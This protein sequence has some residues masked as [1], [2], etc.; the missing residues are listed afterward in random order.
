MTTKTAGLPVHEQLYRGKA[1]APELVEVPPAS[2]LMIDG[3]GDPNTSPAYARAIR[4]LYAA[5]YTVKF[6]VKKAGGPD[7]RVPPLEGLWWGA[8]AAGFEAAGKDSWSWTMMIRLP[9]GAAAGL[10]T[11]ALAEA[12]RRKPD[13]PIGSLRVERF[14]EGRAAQV[15]YV[16]PYAGEQPAIAGLHAFIAAQGG[17]PAGRHHEIYLSDPRRTAPARLKTIVRQ[18]IA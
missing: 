17:R 10:V 9:D 6:A 3:Q 18:P 1:G 5:A 7:G 15:L 13:L 11:A 2:F 4:A 12:A 8:E 14:A 16:G